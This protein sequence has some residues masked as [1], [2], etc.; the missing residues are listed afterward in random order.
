MDQYNSV[1]MEAG[2]LRGSFSIHPDGLASET[3]ISCRPNPEGTEYTS[4]SCDEAHVFV[5][6]N[7]IVRIHIRFEE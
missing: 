6:E 7:G 1:R 5:P 4:L 2:D 3:S